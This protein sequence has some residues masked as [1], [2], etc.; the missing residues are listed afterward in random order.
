MRRVVGKGVNRQSIRRAVRMGVAVAGGLA[1]VLSSA[2]FAAVYTGG[3][4]GTASQPVDG[5]FSTGFNPAISAGGSATLQL[6]FSTSG[7]AY[8]ATDN[9]AG[10]LLLNQLQL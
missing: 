8:T 7:G 2:S 9:L 4:A 6:D 10:A 5:N 1:S 3:G